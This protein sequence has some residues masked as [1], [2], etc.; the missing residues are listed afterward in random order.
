MRIKVRK[1][2]GSAQ[3]EPIGSL[4]DAWNLPGG[5]LGALVGVVAETA[6]HARAARDWIASGF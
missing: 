3:E 5:V 6:K 1:I 2:L 4:L